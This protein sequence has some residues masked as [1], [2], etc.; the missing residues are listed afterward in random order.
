M[1]RN[2]IGRAVINARVD[3][4]IQDNPTAKTKLPNMQIPRVSDLL[5]TM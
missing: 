4:K 1:D 5:K 2:S 3:G